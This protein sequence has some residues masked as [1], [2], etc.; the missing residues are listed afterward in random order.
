MCKA[1][2]LFLV[3][4]CNGVLFSVAH[5]Y[6]CSIN[7]DNVAHTA[8]MTMVAIAESG[9]MR[10]STVKDWLSS[11]GPMASSTTSL[12]PAA[13]TSGDRVASTSA[14]GKQCTEDNEWHTKS[15]IQFHDSS[16]SHW[17][18]RRIWSSLHSINYPNCSGLKLFLNKLPSVAYNLTTCT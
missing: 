2:L 17:V 18:H 16:H 9:I 3:V 10:S 14:A 4:L 13:V 15:T 1:V 8:T 5:L 6:L 11:N 12:A 7:K